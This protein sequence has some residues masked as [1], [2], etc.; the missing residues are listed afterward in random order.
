[1]GLIH[2]LG[3]LLLILGFSHLNERG[4]PDKISK[5]TFRI[6]YP[7]ITRFVFKK[8]NNEEEPSTLSVVSGLVLFLEIPF[9]QISKFKANYII[10]FFK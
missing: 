1:M 4:T 10:I 5:L 8:P 2:F 3:N 6:F 9:L 7:L